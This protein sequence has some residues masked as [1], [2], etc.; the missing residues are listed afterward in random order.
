MRFIYQILRATPLEKDF[1]FGSCYKSTAFRLLGKINAKPYPWKVQFAF[2][3]RMLWLIWTVPFRL[4]RASDKKVILYNVGGS[5]EQRLYFYKKFQN[6]QLSDSQ[7]LTL[8]HDRPTDPLYFAELGPRQVGRLIRG[9]WVLFRATL[10]VAFCRSRINPHWKIRFGN[11]LLQQLLFHGDDRDQM[12]YFCYEPE[13]YLSTLVATSIMPDYFPK[14]VASNSIL[15]RDNRYLVNPRLDFKICSKIQLGET[16]TYRKLGWMKVR[17]VQLWDLEEAM[18][19]DQ[20]QPSPPTCD[21]G[22]Y[23][24]GGWAR[25]HDLWRAADMEVLKKGGYL[26]NPMYLQLLVILDV[27]CTLRKENPKLKVNFYL[28]PHELRLLHQNGIR[29]PYLSI[30]D[31]N[32]ISYSL[33]SQHSIMGIYGPRLGIAVSSTILFDRM[34][35]GLQSFFYAGKAIPHGLIDVRYLGEYAQYGYH[36]AL[37]LREM[38]RRELSL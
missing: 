36:D 29:A 11:L 37:Q 1:G 18:I 23:S 16:D 10:C 14:I 30:L 9:S 2:V 21:I 26:D 35:L 22:I 8:H 33:E 31:A 20:L 25:T 3:L 27:V 34:H 28:H 6:P 24:S 7:V 19:Y 15:F 5:P 38:I 4:R 13:T 17:S 12:L 32:E